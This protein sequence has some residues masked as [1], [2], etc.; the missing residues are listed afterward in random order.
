MEL[1]IIR[2]GI[3]SFGG[4]CFVFLRLLCEKSGSFGAKAIE[5]LVEFVGNFG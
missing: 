5:F 1:S 2:G 3:V 4:G